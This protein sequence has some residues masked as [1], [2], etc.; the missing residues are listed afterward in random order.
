MDWSW[1]LVSSFLR[2]VA[3]FENVAFKVID[4][5]IAVYIN[6]SSHV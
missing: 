1:C 2:A 5:V 4:C 6:S 3:D